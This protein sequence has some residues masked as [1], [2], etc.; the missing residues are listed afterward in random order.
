M[1]HYQIKMPEKKEEGQMEAREAQGLE[2]TPPPGNRIGITEFNEFVRRTN[3]INLDVTVGTLMEHANLIEPSRAMGT[4]G[5]A[6]GGPW[7]VLIGI[8]SS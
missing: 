7:Y 3:V 4:A 6:L 1:T 8:G 2:R 5:G